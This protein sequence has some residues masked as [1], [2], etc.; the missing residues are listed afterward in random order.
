M[1]YSG[2]M[3]IIA[4]GLGGL[5]SVT[6]KLLRSKG[7]KLAIL[8]APF[9]ASKKDAILNNVFGMSDPDGVTTYECDITSEAS[10]DQAFERISMQLSPGVIPN[11]LINAAGYVS[12]QPVEET[13]ADEAGKTI[14]AN[15]IGP[16]NVSR[17]F[18]KL[19]QAQIGEAKQHCTQLPPGRIVSISSQAAHVALDGHAAYCAS[20][21]GLN[22]LTRCMA[23]EWGPK[24]IT[25]NTVSPTV[26]WTELG[27]KAWADD[28]KREK[29]MSLIPTG[30]FCLPQEVADAI[31]FLCRDESGM[32]NG[33][34]L[35]IDG[36]F[37]IR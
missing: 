31:E 9:E 28:G 20:K 30:R 26:A 22:G 7:A 8:Y 17:A 21:A 4:G 18:F 24:G 19:Y 13:L 16:L 32:I 33:A 34:D 11:I 25:S 5:G 12:V 14:M 2:R 1:A 6:G 29:M 15:L 36:G 27:A 10:V 37:T 23:N 35:R 3:A